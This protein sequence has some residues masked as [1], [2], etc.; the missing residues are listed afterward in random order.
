ME[1]KNKI[2]QIPLIPRYF[3]YPHMGLS[4]SDTEYVLLHVFESIF[5]SG[6]FQL[7]QN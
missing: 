3:F 7:T 2:C 4:D 6:N 5:L 1:H